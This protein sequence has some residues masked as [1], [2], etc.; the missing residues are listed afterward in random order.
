VV[1]PVDKDVLPGPQTTHAGIGPVWANVSNTPFRYYKTKVH[2]G[3]IATPLIVHWPAGLAQTGTV[4]AE[5]GHV[6][7]LMATCLDLAGATY[8]ASFRGRSL[9]PMAGKSLVPVIRG[10]Q[11]E[12]ER[13]LYWE[14]FGARAIRQG[15]WKLVMLDQKSD[16]ELYNLAEDKTET[17]NLVRKHPEKVEELSRRW[18]EWADQQNVFPAPNS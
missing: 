15:H 10:Q 1:F 3:G 8:P 9:S 16:W 2:E 5:P 18:Q 14:H 7:D 13:T 6:V 17:N 11:P 12:A 4:T